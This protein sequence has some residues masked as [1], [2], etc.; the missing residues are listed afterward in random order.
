MWRRSAAPHQPGRTRTQ[1]DL[2]ECGITHDPEAI[3][4]GMIAVFTPPPAGI[5]RQAG[6][7]QFY[8]SHPMIECEIAYWQRLYGDHQA[9]DVRGHVLRSTASC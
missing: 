9:D 7:I 2:P 1:G 6:L 3:D 4:D 8:G 5:D